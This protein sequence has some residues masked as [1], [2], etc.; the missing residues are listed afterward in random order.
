MSRAVCAPHVGWTASPPSGIGRNDVAHRS[1]LVTRHRSGLVTS[2]AARNRK[3]FRQKVICGGGSSSTSFSQTICS[4]P[5]KL[6]KANELHPV[7]NDGEG[8]E[9][10]YRCRRVEKLCVCGLVRDVVGDVPI[11]NKLHITV[12]KD[13]IEALKRP[14]GSAIVCELA[15]ENCVSVWY[16]T[17][18]PET[19]PRPK[20][21]PEEGVGVLF[22][23]PVARRLCRT[24]KAF[25][26]SAQQNDESPSTSH[27][28]TTN[29][30][31]HLIVID[32]TWHRARRMYARIPGIKELP[33]YVLGETTP[34]IQ[35]GDASFDERGMGGKKTKSGDGVSGDEF[36]YAA[37]DKNNQEPIVRTESGYRIRKQPKPGFLSTA[38]CIAAALREGEPDDED[39]D[40]NE[41]ENVNLSSGAS[42][43]ALAA[44]AIERCFDLMIDKQVE[45]FSDRKNVRYRSRKRERKAKEAAALLSAKQGQQVT[46]VKSGESLQ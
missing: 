8:R 6:S 9:M 16:D 17:K 36:G 2:N 28:P 18:V 32:T 39:E 37:G 13:R 27:N 30:L 45:S 15:L 22:P 3:S 29:H 31:T 24:K 4:I 26:N 43:G 10:C 41:I 44:D 23:G 12:L 35:T 38:E 11:K 33:S 42:R 46:D 21:L 34:L 14:F 1:R 20:H 5:T 7:P 40:E 25:K 19:V